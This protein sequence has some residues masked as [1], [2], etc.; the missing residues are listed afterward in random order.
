[1]QELKV[2]SIDAP[3]PQEQIVTSTGPTHIVF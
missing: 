1:M 3:G 2:L